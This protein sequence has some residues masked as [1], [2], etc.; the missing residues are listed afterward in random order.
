M[1]PD[2]KSFASL[3]R[4][5]N[6][7]TGDFPVIKTVE[8]QHQQTFSHLPG[9]SCIFFAW[10]IIAKTKDVVLL[11]DNS[12]GYLCL[13]ATPAHWHLVFRDRKNFFGETKKFYFISEYNFLCTNESWS[14]SSTPE[15]K[16]GV[17]SPGML[18]EGLSQ[19]YNIEDIIF[20]HHICQFWYTTAF[21]GLCK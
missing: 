17:G 2:L 7:A 11:A 18:L 4:E 15:N 9:I 5:V 6:Q 19:Y 13:V 14:P 1:S 21:L 3:K 8:K 20:I 16:Q 10:M 12:H